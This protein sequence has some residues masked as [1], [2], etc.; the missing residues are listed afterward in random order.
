MRIKGILT[1]SLGILLAAAAGHAAPGGATISGKVTVDG[2]PAKAM[3]IDM[4]K[5]PD[6]AKQHATP[7]LTETVVV[8]AGN[9]LENVVVFISEGAPDEGTAPTQAVTLDQKGCQ[10]LPHVVPMLVNQEVKIENND[11]TSHNVHPLAKA[12]R[13]WNRAQ[14]AGSPAIGQKFETAEFIPVK[15]N[16][17]A[18]M[19]STFAVMKTSHYFVT[20]EDG[21]FRLPNLPPGKYTITAWHETYGT[22]SQQVTITGA[23]SQNVSFSFKAKLY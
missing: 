20:G 13:E 18:W 15:C 23:E 8:G 1:I 2:T 7:I 22:R 16:V 10:Y 19:H 6:C 17:H 5:E 9:A 4:S 14:P 3:P 11:P 12:N 21:A